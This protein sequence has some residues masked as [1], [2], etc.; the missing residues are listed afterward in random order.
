M[1]KVLYDHTDLHFIFP[2]FL[3]AALSMAGWA[4]QFLWQVVPVIHCVAVYECEDV[5]HS[6]CSGPIR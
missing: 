4:M 1:L 2:C 3:M 6:Q 5:V